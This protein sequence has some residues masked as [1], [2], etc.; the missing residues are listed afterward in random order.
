MAD[1]ETQLAQVP[2][3]N[4][5]HVAEMHVRHFDALLRCDRRSGINPSECRFYAGL[6][7]E[8]LRHLMAG[9]TWKGLP[10]LIRQEYLDAACSGEYDKELGIDTA[11]ALGIEADNYDRREAAQEDEAAHERTHGPGSI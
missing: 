2:P 1:L 4:L 7:R 10:T 6:W 5:A 8:A 11:A 9:V 3:A